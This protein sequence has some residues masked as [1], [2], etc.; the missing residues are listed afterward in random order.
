MGDHNPFPPD[1]LDLE[2][3]QNALEIG[4]S[5][6]AGCCAA[7]VAAKLK[8]QAFALRRDRHLHSELGTGR[9]RLQRIARS[10]RHSLGSCRHGRI[11]FERGNFAAVPGRRAFCQRGGAGEECARPFE[12]SQG[13][14]S[15]QPARPRVGVA[16][17]DR[18][19]HAVFQGP[20]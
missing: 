16:K 18:R 20:N 12:E 2:H 4:A 10:W 6:N 19:E 7:P 5:E 13:Q 1:H 11:L 17:I 8:A 14:P 3:A 15:C 9:G